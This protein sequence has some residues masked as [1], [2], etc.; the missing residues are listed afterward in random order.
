RRR[1]RGAASRALRP[2]AGTHTAHGDDAQLAPPPAADTAGVAGHGAVSS[3]HGHDPGAHGARV[4]TAAYLCRGAGRAP[5]RNSR[6]R[7]RA[8]AGPPPRLVALALL[9]PLRRTPRRM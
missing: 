8:D 4:G 1:P 9:R 7:K 6:E 5:R 2:C 3:A